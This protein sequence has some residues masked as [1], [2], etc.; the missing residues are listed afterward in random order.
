MIDFLV[1]LALNLR[2]KTHQKWCQEALK[3]LKKAIKNVMQVGLAF[4]TLLARILVDF[5]AK[6]GGKLEPSWPHW[7]SYPVLS[8]LILPYLTLPYLTLVILNILATRVL[9]SVDGW[10]QQVSLG[11]TSQDALQDQF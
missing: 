4:G 9:P 3:I 2:P 10:G 6:L 1:N 11:N 5:G 7:R 8:Y